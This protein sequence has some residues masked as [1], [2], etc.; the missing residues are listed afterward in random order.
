MYL[1]FVV[2]MCFVDTPSLNLHYPFSILRSPGSFVIE[3]IAQ[4]KVL[5]LKQVTHA[6]Y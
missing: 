6:D 1:C 5:I 2:Y 3:N 4:G